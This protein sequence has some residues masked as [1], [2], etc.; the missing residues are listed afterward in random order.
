MMSA[1]K[2][3]LLSCSLALTLCAAIAPTVQGDCKCHKPERGEKTR[4]DANMPVTMKLEGQFRELKGLVQIDAERPMEDVLVEIFDKP[5]YLLGGNPFADHPNQ[6]RLKACV[7]SADGKFCLRGLSSG[8]YEIR[9]SKDGGW[10]ITYA[11]VELDQKHGTKE[12]IEINMS[13][14]V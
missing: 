1:T 3:R 12:P 13:I 6:K 10:N 14:G 11:Y 5:D 2:S 9:V 4:Q 8:K 7:T